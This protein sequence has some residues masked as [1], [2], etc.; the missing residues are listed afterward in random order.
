[1]VLK[2]VGLGELH[3]ILQI[4][5]PEEDLISKEASK[6]H[7]YIPSDRFVAESLLTPD[8]ETLPC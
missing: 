3:I 2:T 5:Q 6:K 4:V 1:M 8:L 7:S